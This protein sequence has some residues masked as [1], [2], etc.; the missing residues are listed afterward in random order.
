M[1]IVQTNL[2]NIIKSLYFWGESSMHTEKLVVHDCSQGEV[3]EWRHT[4]FVDFFSV[5]YLTWKLMIRINQ[6]CVLL[7]TILISSREKLVVCDV[8]NLPYMD[9]NWQSISIYGHFVASLSAYY[10]CANIRR[11]YAIPVID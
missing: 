2:F 6:Y 7:T 3:V 9:I 5:L 8:T 10:S 4:R 11:F 1:Q